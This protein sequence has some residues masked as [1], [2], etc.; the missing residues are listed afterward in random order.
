MAKNN[1]KLYPDLP[2][3]STSDE[4]MPDLLRTSTEEREFGSIP[5]SSIATAA[6]L[7]HIKAQANPVVPRGPPKKK[8]IK[9]QSIALVPKT[10][11]N[12]P[13]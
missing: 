10:P 3:D 2:D 7:S 8:K 6:A 13:V 11:K 1:T 5:G 9:K 4:E 12:T